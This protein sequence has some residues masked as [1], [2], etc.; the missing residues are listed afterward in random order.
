MVL[1]LIDLLRC[2]KA[3]QD[4]PLVATIHTRSDRDIVAG[5]L[6]CPVCGAE[7]PIENGI[8]IFGEGL[9]PEPARVPE[10]Y[11]E[12][13]EE[14]AM[15]CAAMLA[16]FDPGG[17]VILGGAWGRCAATLLEM[18]RVSLLLV[19]PPPEIRLGNAIA[20]IRVGTTIPLAPASARGIALDD[21]TSVPSLVVSAA[22]ALKPG[23]RLVASAGATIPAG[24]VERARDD[25][26]WVGEA[27]PAPSAPVQLTKGRAR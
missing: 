4:S 7:Y 16:L 25:R 6:G 20:G 3:H 12:T 18:T 9:P 19:E 13:D 11:A 21:R 1:E 26:H 23:A 8:A 17:V 2:T 15:R 22:R 10:P 5:L 24:I 27:A 14:A